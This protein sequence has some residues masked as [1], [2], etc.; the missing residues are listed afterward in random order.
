MKYTSTKKVTSCDFIT[1]HTLKEQ[2]SSKRLRVY[3]IHVF[4]PPNTPHTTQIGHVSRYVEVIPP[5]L[6]ATHPIQ[7]FRGLHV[8]RLQETTDDLSVLL[9]RQQ[10]EEISQAQV[11]EGIGY[12][13]EVVTKGGGYGRGNFVRSALILE[14]RT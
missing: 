3:L 8:V 12:C 14:G 6:A 13:V 5:N 11:T 9:D 10:R 2:R 7:S 1:A 4:N